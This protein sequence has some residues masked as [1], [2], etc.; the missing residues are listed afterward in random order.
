M[1]LQSSPL[2]APLLCQLKSSPHITTEQVLEETFEPPVV[3]WLD[4]ADH[5]WPALLLA[6]LALLG[7]ALA[8]S[9]PKTK[10]KGVLKP[11]RQ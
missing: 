6:A 3:G 4:W 9:P 11:K 8:L 5:W 10:R 1:I 2:R 7:A